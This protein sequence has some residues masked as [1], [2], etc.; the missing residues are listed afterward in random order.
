MIG[1]YSKTN[2]A[3]NSGLS[4]NQKA[5][6]IVGIVGVFLCVLLG[7]LSIIPWQVAGVLIAVSIGI[8]TLLLKF[9]E[10]YEGNK[11]KQQIPASTEMNKE[12]ITTES[13]PQHNMSVI[14]KLGTEEDFLDRTYEEA[15]REAVTTFGDAQLSYFAIQ[16]VYENASPPNLNVYFHFYSKWSNRVCTFQ[17]SDI[18]FKLKHY[19]PNKHAKFD[20]EK[21]TFKDL[22]WKTSPRFLQALSRSYDKIKPLPAVRGTYYLI[23]K[24]ASENWNIKF[25]DGSNGNEYSFEWDGLGLDENSIKQ[26]N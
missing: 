9:E 4:M 23:W 22:P 16:G 21:E 2:T 1:T 26:T 20:F 12:K 5:I 8:P 3:T 7:A 10:K 24:R 6:V 25:E 18:D 17:Y 11:K 13:Q 15:R 19:K 14:T